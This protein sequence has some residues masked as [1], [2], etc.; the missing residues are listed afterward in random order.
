MIAPLIDFFDPIICKPPR[1]AMTRLS[2][3]DYTALI[4]GR[5][6]QL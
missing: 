1:D 3:N 5:A 2:K 6:R 4:I